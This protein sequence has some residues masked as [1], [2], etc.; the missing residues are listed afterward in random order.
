[1]FGVVL[2]LPAASPAGAN[3]TGPWNGSVTIEGVTYTPGNPV[4]LPNE[5]GVVASWE[6]RT[7]GAIHNHHGEIGIDVGPFT[8]EVADWAGDNEN[9][10]VT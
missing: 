8:I 4:V 9:D 1:V 2:A 6:G 7:D 5:E 10:E 3:V